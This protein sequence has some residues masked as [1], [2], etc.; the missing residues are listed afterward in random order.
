MLLSAQLYILSI[1][2]KIYCFYIEDHIH[3]LETIVF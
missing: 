3:K 1:V 2:Q